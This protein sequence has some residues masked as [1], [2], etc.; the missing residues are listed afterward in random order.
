MANHKINELLAVHFQKQNHKNPLNFFIA[1]NK[2]CYN[3]GVFNIF[4][5]M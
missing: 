3:M 4:D 1:K 5:M 2:F